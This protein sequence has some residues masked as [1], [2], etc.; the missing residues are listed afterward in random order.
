MRILLDENIP[1]QLARELIGHQVRTVGRMGWRGVK[2]GELLRRAVLEF[3]VFLTIDQS[4]ETQLVLP[5]QLALLTLE[6]PSNRIEDLFPLMPAVLHAIENIQP[7][8]R[9]RV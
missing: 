8:E 7:G 9:V 1:V 6:A 2:N 3:D 4:I 5:Q